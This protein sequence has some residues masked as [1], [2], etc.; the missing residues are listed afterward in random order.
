[1]IP[2]AKLCL[3]GLVVVLWLAVPA[4]GQAPAA[5]R[6]DPSP[7]VEPSAI[8]D[9]ESYRQALR[10]LATALRNENWHGARVAAESLRGRQFVSQGFVLAVDA[11]LLAAVA[12]VNDT[13]DARPVLERLH[14]LQ[15]ALDAPSP[16]SVGGVDEDLLQ[17]I[18]EEQRVEA[19][20]AEG[21]LASVDVPSTAF[22]NPF[23][24]WLGGVLTSLWERVEDWLR[25]LLDHWRGKP[26]VRPRRLDSTPDW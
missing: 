16:E 23:T 26:S 1:M 12:E 14:A 18:D 21:K 22:R 20:R 6:S 4:M 24:R 13:A 2:N 17:R 8:L 5:S 19:L 7:T 11:S 15:Q 25:W 9:V 3:G 10:S